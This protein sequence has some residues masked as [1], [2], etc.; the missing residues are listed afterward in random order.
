MT[1]T[2]KEKT[3]K[4][5]SYLASFDIGTKNLSFYIEKY[6]PEKLSDIPKT[7]KK[8]RVLPN[9]KH[10][11]EYAKNIRKLYR[12]GKCIFFLKI[13]VGIPDKKHTGKIDQE[14]FCNTTK[15][16]DSHK[17]F[18]DKCSAII[19]EQ[20]MS[21]G[22]KINLRAIKMAQHIYSHFVNTFL[23]LKVIFEFSSFHKTQVLCDSLTKGGKKLGDKQRKKWSIE[24]AER[25]L[26]IRNDFKSVQDLNKYTK[27]DDICD[28]ILQA[29][30]WKYLL[31][32]EKANL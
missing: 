2:K 29:Q 13:N 23:G 5:Y 4:K 26:I 9:G 16:L 10:T 25:L 32:V 31:Y 14:V 24:E 15:M 27:K 22:K 18:F 3:L 6:D 12:S 30:A 1:T 7:L 21:F 20:Q 11:K 17:H 28:C 8:N 19:I